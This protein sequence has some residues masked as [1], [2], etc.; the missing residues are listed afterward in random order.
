MSWSMFETGRT[1]GEIGPRSGRILRDD[2]HANGARI[3]LEEG[4]PQAPYVITCSIQHPAVEHVYATRASGTAARVFNAMKAD[5]ETL[6][7]LIR[8]QDCSAE[9]RARVAAAVDQ[10]VSAYR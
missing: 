2:V 4:A 5:L 9:A 8:A 6:Q 7:R 3:T 1:L 10:F